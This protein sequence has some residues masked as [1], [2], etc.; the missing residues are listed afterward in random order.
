MELKRNFEADKLGENELKFLKDFTKKCRGDILKMTTVASSGHPGGSMSSIDI[1]AVL[2]GFCNIDPKNPFK[3]E[4]DRIVVSHGHT[5]P[6]VYSA[7][8]NY[9]FFDINDAIIS[10]RTAGYPFE[11]HI[12]KTV[13]GV[14]WDTGNLGQG[15][16]AACA[17]ALSSKLH[18]YNNHVYCI[19]GD[20]EQAK[21]QIGEARRFAVK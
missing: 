20:G 14:E 15:L 2:Y 7:L 12:E 8:G 21:G 13:P 6:G 17:F 1:Y 4:R 18:D 5:S 19:M 9:G 3:P 16:S 10:F 11:G